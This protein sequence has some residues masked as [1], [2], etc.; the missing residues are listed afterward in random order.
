[1][2]TVEGTPEDPGQFPG[3]TLLHEVEGEENQGTGFT[4]ER[5]R[6]RDQH[7]WSYD[8]KI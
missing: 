3:I 4:S 6:S 5:G 2:N 8:H 7:R 1:L